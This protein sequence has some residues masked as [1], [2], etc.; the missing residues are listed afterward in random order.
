M[1]KAS[2]MVQGPFECA[3]LTVLP[4]RLGA[5]L[6]FLPFPTKL[7]AVAAVDTDAPT[8]RRAVEEHAQV[9]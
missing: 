7:V 4:P 8:G 5:P 2:K 3:P 6:L 1:D 9:W